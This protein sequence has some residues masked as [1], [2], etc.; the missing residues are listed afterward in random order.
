MWGAHLSEGPYDSGIAD[1]PLAPCPVSPSA[2]QTP[3]PTLDQLRA[4][5][6]FHLSELAKRNEHH[7]FERICYELARVRIAPNILPATGPVG[8]GGDQGRDFETYRTYVCG[9]AVAPRAL[10]GRANGD[11][12]VFTCSTGQSNV[13]RKILDDIKAVM[14]GQE[15]PDVIYH[16]TTADVPVAMRH[17]IKETCLSAHGVKLEIFDL[18]ALGDMMAD[19]DVFW[20]TSQY[21]HLPAS[22]LPPIPEDDPSWYAATRERWTARHGSTA[23][24]AD[25]DDLRTAIRHASRTNDLAGDVPFWAGRLREYAASQGSPRLTRI[26]TYEETYATW[27]AREELRGLET[28]LREYFDETA[29]FG[30]ADEVDDATVLV[31]LLAGSTARGMIDLTLAEVGGWQRRMRV[32]LD[33]RIIAASGPTERTR[34]LATAGF[35]V[36]APDVDD[37]ESSPKIDQALRHWHALLNEVHK[38]PLFALDDFARRMSRMAPALD[39]HPAYEEFVQKLDRAAAARSGQRAVAKQASGRALAFAG[40]DRP[41]RAIH[42]LHQAKVDWFTT[43]TLCSS[44]AAMLL[45]C[46]WYRQLGMTFAAKK[47][48]LAAAY[49]AANATS[50]ADAQAFAPRAMTLVALADFQQGSW[51]AA[52]GDAD[53]A[54]RYHAVFSPSHGGERFEDDITA[55]GYVASHLVAS[56]TAFLPALASQIAMVTGLWGQDK[57]LSEAVDLAR[58]LYGNNLDAFWAEMTGQ[59]FDAAFSDVGLERT[60]PWEALGLTFEIRYSNDPETVPLAEEFLATLQ[61]VLSDLE[62]QELLVLP[63]HVDIA[64]NAQRGGT[65]L[66]TVTTSS[67]SS[68]ASR[69]WA[70]SLRVPD[71]MPHASMQEW[72]T[73]I[74]GSVLHML[75]E[76]T[77]LPSQQFDALLDRL[78]R[79]N[80]PGKVS[81]ALPYHVLYGE[82]LLDHQFLGR[83]RGADVRALRLRPL[84]RLSI[85]ELAWRDTPGPGYDAAA[86][87]DRIER[88]YTKAL[89]PCKLTLARLRFEGEFIA[90]VE[91]L[92]ND[93]WKDW[94]ILMAVAA[95]VVTT[96][97][98]DAL[99]AASDMSAVRQV[100]AG[101]M[102][103]PESPDERPIP[104]TT[105]S[106]SRLRTQMHLN[107]MNE[108]HGLGLELHQKVP[109]FEGLRRFFAAR[110][111]YL[112]DDCPHAADLLTPG[113][114]T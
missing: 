99:Q 47:Y 55:L 84:P 91:T 4:Q 36:L 14:G 69:S 62:D 72:E 30:S 98:Q 15:K 51:V 67:R 74:V 105:F 34:L 107:M 32:L 111:R 40:A 59:L 12:L 92:R 77:L 11:L 97:A 71:K 53:A 90:A 80:M 103:R 20:I 49:I 29:A 42:E 10:V 9:L 52:L 33:E 70:V 54:V 37:N 106:E 63:T 56:S 2:S 3:S 100:M 61:I 93:G 96:R 112:D 48:G 87:A 26:A 104:A 110:Y 66:P 109:D 79:R 88:R 18:Q 5:I 89:I 102:E 39:S 43:E 46:D 1:Q 41:L 57:W 85:R 65:R 94:H 60:V 81:V 17:K 8:A 108:I 38:A 114:L 95:I 83:L 23:N 44:L 13:R 45:L 50:D 58:G 19:R 27:Y 28:E 25:F 75:R 21:L 73:Q 76:T 31:V 16:F 86:A 24:L 68:N 7:A 101:A 6:R 113:V 64:V 82:M 22:L 78:M 35:A